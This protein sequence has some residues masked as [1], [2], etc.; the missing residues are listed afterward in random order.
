MLMLN[1]WNIAEKMFESNIAKWLLREE[2]AI[3]RINYLSQQACILTTD[4]S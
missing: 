1:G 3:Q 2:Y 4:E